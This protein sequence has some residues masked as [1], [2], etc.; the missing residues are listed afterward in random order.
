MTGA[1]SLS[2]SAQPVTE[3]LSALSLSWGDA[4]LPAEG[5]GR[6]SGSAAGEG[7]PLRL[8]ETAW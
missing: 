1:E 7:L 4:G 2:V 5:V 6:D 3:N 8:P